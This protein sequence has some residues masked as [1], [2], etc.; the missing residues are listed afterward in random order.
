MLAAILG[1]GSVLF[2]IL[3]IGHLT[4]TECRSRRRGRA[5]LPRDPACGNHRGQWALYAQF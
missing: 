5:H 2:L 1:G 3:S 4:T